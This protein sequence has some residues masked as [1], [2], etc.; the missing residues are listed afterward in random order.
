VGAVVPRDRVHYVAVTPTLIEIHPE[1]RG[2]Y[3]FVVD[4]ELIIVDSRGHIV[5]IVEV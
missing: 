5:A 4:E 2:H 3:Y 1:W